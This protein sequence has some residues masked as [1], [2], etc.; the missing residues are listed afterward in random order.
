MT[1]IKIGLLNDG[2]SD[3][4]LSIHIDPFLEHSAIG[5]TRNG[6]FVRNERRQRPLSSGCSVSE[7]K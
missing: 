2:S 7:A 5:D 3:E 1:T 6:R 4:Q